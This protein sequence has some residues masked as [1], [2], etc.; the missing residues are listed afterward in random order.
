[1]QPLHETVVDRD[2]AIVEKASERDVMVDDVRARRRQWRLRRLVGSVRATPRQELVVDRLR[3]ALT[4]SCSFEFAEPSGFVN[5]IEVE[6]QLRRGREAAPTRCSRARAQ[7]V[8]LPANE[9]IESS[10]SCG[11][12]DSGSG[13]RA[14]ARA[15]A[16]WVYASS[17]MLIVTTPG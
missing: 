5:W 3:L 11:A 8:V 2:E 14:A 15:P 12:R 17:R 9:R 16:M 1:M 6:A 13:R 7:L 4:K 10:N